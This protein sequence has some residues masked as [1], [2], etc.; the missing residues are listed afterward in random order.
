[1]SHHSAT[2]QSVWLVRKARHGESSICG[3][4]DRAITGLLW[5]SIAVEMML[6]QWTGLVLVL[7]IQGGRGAGKYWW[8]GTQAFGEE[9]EQGG[10]G[11]GYQQDLVGN[12]L[13]GNQ[14]M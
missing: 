12:S 3:G 4:Y 1:M 7:L 5:S 8:M 9:G 11:G 13:Q 14:G 6:L 2:P 10:G